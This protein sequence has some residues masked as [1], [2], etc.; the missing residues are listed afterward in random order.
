MPVATLAAHLVTPDFPK[1]KCVTPNASENRGG[2][3]INGHVEKHLELL[4]RRITV[5]YAAYFFD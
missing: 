2:D 4:K 5:G 1:D 3:P